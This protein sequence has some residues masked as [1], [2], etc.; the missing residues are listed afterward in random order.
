MGRIFPELERGLRERVDFGLSLDPKTGVI[1][2]RGEFGETFAVDGQCGTILRAYREHQMSP[3]DRF[4]KR[5]WPGIKRALQCVID[6]D[7]DGSGVLHGPMHNTLDA[8]WYGVVPWLVGLY[9]AALAPA[10][11]WPG[12]RRRRVRADLPR[13]LRQRASSTSTS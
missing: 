7:T 8:D 11:R 10:R 2:F 5:L 1:H 6:R 3:D 4:L 13:P 9:H 12:S